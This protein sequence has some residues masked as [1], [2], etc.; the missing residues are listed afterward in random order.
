[1]AGGMDLGSGSGRGSKRALDASLNLVPFIDLMAVTIVFLIMT[2]VWTQLGGLRVASSA[3]AGCVGCEPPS[4]PPPRVLLSSKGLTLSIDGHASFEAP[5]Q[6]TARGRLELSSTRAF[7]DVWKAQHP[8]AASVRLVPDDDVPSED[9]VQ[10]MD[11]LLGAGF[12][13]LALE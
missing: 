4:S 3:A 10:V 6:R 11:L 8:D 12:P 13:E 5:L 7:L 1:M 2:A 9:V